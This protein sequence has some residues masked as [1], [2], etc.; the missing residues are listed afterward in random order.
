MTNHE[1]LVGSTPMPK[2]RVMPLVTLTSD[3]G[4]QDYYAA[5]VKAA[6]LKHAP[7]ATLVDISHGIEPLNVVQGIHMLQAVYDDFPK[8]TVHIFA[9]HGSQP[10]DKHIAFQ[11][12][13]HYF[14][15]SDNGFVG[16]LASDAVVPCVRLEANNDQPTTFPAQA[17]YAPAAA[18][19]LQTVA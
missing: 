7:E 3:F 1:L 2:F 9:V 4:Y 19:L 10:T 5:A 15:G 13:G 17:L 16:L 11:W 12:A 8:G 14:V 6:V 18:Q